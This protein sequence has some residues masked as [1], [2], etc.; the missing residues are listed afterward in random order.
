MRT[1]TGGRAKMGMYGGRRFPIREC[2]NGA[3]LIL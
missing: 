3:I 2:F 1:E